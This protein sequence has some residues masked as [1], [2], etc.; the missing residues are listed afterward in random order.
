MHLSIYPSMALQPLWT[1]TAFSVLFYTQSVGL[2]ERGSG[3][4][5]TQNKRTPMP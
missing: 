3:A 2:L 5:Y 4:I 1:L